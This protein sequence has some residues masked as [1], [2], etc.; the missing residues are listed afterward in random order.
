MRPY[1]RATASL[2]VFSFLSNSSTLALNQAASEI[3]HISAGPAP[4][5]VVE[6][7][8]IGMT[9]TGDLIEFVAGWM[10]GAANS[11]LALDAMICNIEAASR[12]SVGGMVCSRQLL[13]PGV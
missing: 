9:C 6:V 5:A 11:F 7:P 10:L 2:A 4:S 3:V 13:L 12:G 1:P 8:W